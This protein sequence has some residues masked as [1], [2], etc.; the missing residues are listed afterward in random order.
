LNYAAGQVVA[1]GATIKLGVGGKICVFTQ[2]AMDLI[3]DVSGY[4]PI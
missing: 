3:V 2:Q 4:H 1:N